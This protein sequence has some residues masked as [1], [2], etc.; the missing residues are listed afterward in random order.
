MEEEDED[1]GE[2]DDDDN[3]DSRGTTDRLSM[4]GIG[5]GSADMEYFSLSR[6]DKAFFRLEQTAIEQREGRLGGQRHG[7]ER[8]IFLK[9]TREE[10]Y[11][12]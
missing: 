4:A 9:T 1:G 8:W 7:R 10:K 2:V 5:D 6:L 12:I 3:E 11:K